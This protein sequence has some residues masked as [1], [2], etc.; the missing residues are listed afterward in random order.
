MEDYS[1]LSAPKSLPRRLQRDEAT[2]KL[3]GADAETCIKMN[4]ISVEMRRIRMQFKKE[5]GQ[6]VVNG[7][8]PANILT[9]IFDPSF[10]EI[11]STKRQRA[12]LSVRIRS[13]LEAIPAIGPKKAESMLMKAQLPTGKRKQHR[14]AYL[15]SKHHRRNDLIEVL[16]MW[17][18]QYWSYKSKR[19]KKGK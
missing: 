11:T 7:T 19:A 1:D 13:F 17:F 16:S 14:I 9:D 12:I 5:I 10:K 8:S 2:G 15:Q 18:D 6:R 4:Q 3:Y